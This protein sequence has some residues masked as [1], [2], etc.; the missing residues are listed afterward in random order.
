MSS[1]EIDFVGSLAHSCLHCQDLVLDQRLEPLESPEPVPPS[2]HS[3]RP[4]SSAL[5]C[6]EPHSPELN[7]LEPN[8]SKLVDFK[9]DS[10]THSLTRRSSISM[11]LSSDDEAG[12]QSLLT[13]HISLKAAYEASNDG[14][15]F[16]QY[17]TPTR[18]LARNRPPG[19]IKP[20]DDWYLKLRLNTGEY[21]GDYYSNISASFEAPRKIRGQDRF[22]YSSGEM[23]L[24]VYTANGKVL[25]VNNDMRHFIT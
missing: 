18:D 10:S 13:K 17:I 21:E 24:G 23:S 25:S 1:T 14:C 4:E 8:P 22:K 16:M 20:E 19:Y 2:S 12:S 3:S 11:S 5:S 6:S 9:P 15:K 7:S